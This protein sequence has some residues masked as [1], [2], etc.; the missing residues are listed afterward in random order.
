MTQ[1][2]DQSAELA[3]DGATEPTSPDASAPA[4]DEATA[5]TAQDV[6]DEATP[7]EA[8]PTEAAAE[9]EP[10]PA[11][12]FDP[13]AL[14]FVLPSE[15][16]EA[17]NLAREMIDGFFAESAD[18]LV[19]LQRA[20]ETADVDTANRVAHRLKGAC[21]M[22][23]FRQIEQL[24]G[25][26]ETEARAGKPADAETVAKLTPAFETARDAAAR[27]IDQFAKRAG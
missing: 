16:A 8:T 3:A 26:I 18:R 2:P 24:T 21:S 14:E 19:D 12:A 25:Q 23:G 15:P 9:A 22:I 6:T 20:A 17:L 27:W 10:P 11:D 5:P 7:T 4:T 13:S 1:T